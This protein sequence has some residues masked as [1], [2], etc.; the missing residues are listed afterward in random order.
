ML[1]HAFFAKN[2]QAMPEKHPAR[3]DSKHLFMLLIIP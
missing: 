2:E 3:L 1:F